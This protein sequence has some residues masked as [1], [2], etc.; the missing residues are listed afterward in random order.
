[1]KKY[2]A[3]V[4]L[5][6]M[7]TAS[8][9]FTR[10]RSEYQTVSGDVWTTQYHITFLAA[11]DNHLADSVRA[12]LGDVDMSVSPFNPKSRISE[13]NTGKTGETDSRFR[14]L[15]NASLQVNRESGGAFD[16]T[17]MPLV[18][19]WGFGYKKGALPTQ[20]QIDSILSFVGLSKTRLAG[21]KIVRDDER[22]QFDFSSIAKGLACDEVGEMLLRNGVEHFLVEIGGEVVAHGENERGEPWHIS[23]DMPEDNLQHR[24]A[25][26]LPLSDK[27]VA[28]SGNYRRYKEVDGKRVSHIV[29]PH[30]G[31][32]E[33]SSLLS[34]TIVAPDCM[35]ADAWATAC[36]A[37]G[38][39]RAHAL[40]ERRS[41]IA[42][43]TI[44]TDSAG[45]YIAWSNAAFANLLP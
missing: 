9:F 45:N 7:G 5:A 38:A 2:I 34:V 31:H 23:V 33:E 43:M 29:N 14:R 1:M 36:M 21:S 37:M 25:L 41:D 13:I 26:V 8:L 20:A 3:V 11:T 28:T 35:T 19:A 6:V 27:A 42:A 15:Y 4:I 10:E 17:V 18:N 39:E 24:S 44:S 30:T 22:T 32:A 16:P 12:I 40:M